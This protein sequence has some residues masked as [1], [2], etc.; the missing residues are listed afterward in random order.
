MVSFHLVLVI[1]ISDSNFLPNFNKK[2]TKPKK[3]TNFPVNTVFIFNTFMIESE[4]A[5]ESEKAPADIENYNM[6][7][8]VKT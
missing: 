6:T 4:A 1:F 7:V 2:S 8:T 3:P 5:L